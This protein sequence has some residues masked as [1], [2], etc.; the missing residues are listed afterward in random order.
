MIL[1]RTSAISNR[2]ESLIQDNLIST[3][4]LGDL[5]QVLTAGHQVV[6]TNKGDEGG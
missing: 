5:G 6:N 3:V 4:A 2:K 1:M